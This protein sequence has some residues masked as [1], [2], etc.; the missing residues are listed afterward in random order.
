M[1]RKKSAKEKANEQD[2]ELAYQ[3]M[4]FI[5]EKKKPLRIHLE[6]RLG[7]SNVPP[8]A[9]S[10]KSI[11]MK[12]CERNQAFLSFLIENL[13]WLWDAIDRSEKSGDILDEVEK[14]KKEARLKRE[15][16]GEVDDL[17]LGA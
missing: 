17:S 12:I 3:M 16:L 8:D 11:D 6:G 2:L 13:N 4:E 15:L 9:D 5:L 10:L 7:R 1:A 14:R